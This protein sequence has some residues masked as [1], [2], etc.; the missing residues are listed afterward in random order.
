MDYGLLH[1]LL[2]VMPTCAQEFSNPG[3]FLEEI[4]DLIHSM[5]HPGIRATQCSITSC[6]IWLSEHKTVDRSGLGHLLVL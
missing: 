2:L 3:S 1:W 6:F 4:F 5:S